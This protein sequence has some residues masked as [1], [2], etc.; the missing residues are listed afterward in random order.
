MKGMNSIARSASDITMRILVT[1]GVPAVAYA[2]ISYVVTSAQGPDALD[3]DF[4]TFMAAMALAMLLAAVW[5]R[6]DSRR[7]TPSRVVLTWVVV[8]V[9]SGLV[10]GI[11]GTLLAPGSPTSERVA[12]A[13][14][15]T[16][17]YTIPLGLAA[18]LGLG[19]GMSS[20]PRRALADTG[21][22]NKGA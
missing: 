13:V 19:V 17:F 14:S 7:M 20:R 1:L 22:Q 8:A 21:P 9:A 16:S 12:E 11:G 18:L 15:S 4:F 10:L 3:G 5:S 6:L 2:A